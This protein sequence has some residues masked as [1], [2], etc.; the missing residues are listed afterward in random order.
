MWK[1]LFSIRFGNYL[2]REKGL[3]LITIC[4]SSGSG[5]NSKRRKKGSA[6]SLIA[7]SQ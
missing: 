2:S 5:E 6:S 1:T 3:N 4:K 7:C